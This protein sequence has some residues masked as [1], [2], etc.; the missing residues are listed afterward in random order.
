MSPHPAPLHRRL[1]ATKASKG[2]HQPIK[3]LAHRDIPSQHALGPPS[4][5]TGK[6]LASSQ[7]G[8]E[9][10]RLD[11]P[12]GR[13]EEGVNGLGFAATAGIQ[14]T[15]A[16]GAAPRAGPYQRSDGRAKTTDFSKAG[17]HKVGH[18]FGQRC[19]GFDKAFGAGGWARPLAAQPMLLR[20]QGWLQI[21]AQQAAAGRPAG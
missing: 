11:V 19:A 15:T 9:L 13:K 20:W 8:E 5:N 21:G 14:W 3:R 10:R 4:P 16:P 12:R 18:D 6:P 7:R 17:V 1:H 2:S